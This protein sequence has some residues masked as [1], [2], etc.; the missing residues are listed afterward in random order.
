VALWRIRATVDDRPGYL[1]VLTASLALRAVNILAVQVH[2]TEAGAVDDFLVD[3]PDALGEAE[4]L[5]AIARGRGREAYI[6]RAEAQGLADL[7]TRVLALAG[8]LVH[9][10]DALGEALISLLDATEVRWRPEPPGGRPGFD[11]TRMWLADP[12]GGSYEVLRR[13]PAFTPAEFA[14]ARALVELAGTVQRRQDERVT[15]LLPDGAELVLRPA[16]SDDLEGVRDL[17]RRVPDARLRRLLEPAGGVCLLAEDTGGRIVA[18]ASLV[19]EGDLGEPAVLVDADWRRRGLG[20]ALLR[21]LMVWAGRNDLAALVAHVRA[22]DVAMLR[23]LRRLGAGPADQD[24]ALVSI[25]L[26]VPSVRPVGEESP[27]LG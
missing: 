8:R 23:T 1:S 9:D 18:T 3:A 21:R 20:T 5:A 25:T 26:P 22:D 27:A 2:T 13:Q 11:E 14:R 24:G 6:T 17:H 15:M 19:V 16:A 4:L 7:P 10:P 12:V